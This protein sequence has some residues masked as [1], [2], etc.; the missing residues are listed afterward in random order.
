MTERSSG[1]GTD[2][3]SSDAQDGARGDVQGDAQVPGPAGVD[4]AIL[5][6]GL[7]LEREDP[8][9]PCRIGYE[10]VG[11]P[12]GP[13]VVVL[14]GISADRHLG[15]HEADDRPGWWQIMVGPDR[16]LDTRRFRVVGLDWIGGPGDSSA[17]NRRPGPDGIPAV[18]TGD[19]AAAVAAVMDD[20]GIERLHALV[21]ASFGAMV[22]LAFGVRFPER[23]RHIL[24]ISGAHM[25]HPMATALR[26][27]QRRVVLFGQERGDAEGALIIA[28]SIGM[29][30]YRSAEEFR[31]RFDMEPRLEAGR[32]RFPVEDYLEYQGR[33]FASRYRPEH[34]LYLCQSLD[35]HRV[36]PTEVKAP[37]TILA[38][39]ED[40]LVP[41]WQMRELKEGMG[42]LAELVEI[43]A[44][45]G[46][47]A[48]LTEEELVGPVIRRV[49]EASHGA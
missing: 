46:H 43:S 35:L 12:D 25:S 37:T 31:Q 34:F 32:Y 44:L 23:V 27:L 6:E 24:A 22:G 2:T 38:V 11:N 36:D 28:R 16:V 45:T 20:L 48:F 21:G 13:V 5:P 49:L 33:K 42:E 30:T 19:Q 8:I 1:S 9:V 29:T 40:E 14:G 26:S 41:L 39:A 17:P 7:Q 18:T 10:W 15:S 4:V 47:D 3:G